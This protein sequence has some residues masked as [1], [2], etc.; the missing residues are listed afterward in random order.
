MLLYDF[1]TL[2][3]VFKTFQPK[4][5]LNYVFKEKRVLVLLVFFKSNLSDLA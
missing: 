1:L 3:Q 5:D 2:E 4:R